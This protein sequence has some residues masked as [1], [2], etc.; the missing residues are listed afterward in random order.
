VRADAIY[1]NVTETQTNWE[2]VWE[3][4]ASITEDGWVV[5]MAIPFKTLSFDSTTET[6]GINFTRRLARNAETIGWLSRTQAQNPG[7]SGVANGL[8]GLEQGRELDVVP[9]VSAQASKQFAPKL[10][11][12]NA[13]PSLDIFYKF[14]P[15]VTGAL[16]L[17][18]DF[19][20]TEVDD[21]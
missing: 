18:T 1:E 19:S 8:Y 16:T 20:A 4:Q 9:S 5:E 21:R 13:G 14:T 15:A 3:A 12:N 17:N 2:G 6:W 10:T 11:D 7:V